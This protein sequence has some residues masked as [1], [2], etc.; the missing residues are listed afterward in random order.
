MTE[1]SSGRGP[2]FVRYF[3]PV[4]EALRALGGSGRPAEVEAFVISSLGLSDEVQNET[5]TSGQSR[6]RNQVAWA[7]FYL[8]KAGLVVSSS[9]G[10]WSL[11]EEG[12]HAVLSQRAALDLFKSVH[13]QFSH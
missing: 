2:Q 1:R 10:V 7:K 4:I 9:R 12:Q 6:F 13:V 5:T 3:G 11:T 8:V